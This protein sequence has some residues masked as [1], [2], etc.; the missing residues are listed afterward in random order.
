MG[1]R[2]YQAR[3]SRKLADVNSTRDER[4][5]APQATPIIATYVPDAMLNRAWAAGGYALDRDLST[6]IDIWLCE[7]P[8]REQV[9]VE[10]ELRDFW[11]ANNIWFMERADSPY[12]FDPR[13]ADFQT[14]IFADVRAY[15]YAPGQIMITDMSIKDVLNT[16]DLS[17]VRRAVNSEGRIV[18]G[19][20][21]T[22]LQQ[23]ITV[24]RPHER[25]EER[26]RKYMQR[27]N[28]KQG[29]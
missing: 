26:L 3:T 22:N 23:P 13:R 6:D 16:F 5:I 9:M 2:I 8:T 17:I 11:D 10:G 18:L 25:S 14:E 15:G 1:H 24:L 27:F 28:L 19:E 29:V 12:D 4:S 7:I 20:G 21:A